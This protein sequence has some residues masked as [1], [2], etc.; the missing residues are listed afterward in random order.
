MMETVP[1]GTILHNYYRIER[2]LGSGGFGHVYQSIDLRTNQQYA[3]KEYLVTGSGGQEQLQHE[4]QMLNKLHHPNLPIFHDAFS[5]RGHYYVVLSY[6]EGNDLTDLL[7]VAR[8]RN[9]TIPLP[10][11]LNW[12][13]SICDAVTFLHSQR[14]PVIHRDIK[15]DNIRVTPEGTAILVDLGNAKAAAEGMRTLLFI[16]HQGTPGYAPPE[17]YPGG[18]GTDTRSDVY[19]LGGTLYFALTTHEPPSVSARNTSLQQGQVDLPSLQQRLASN[20]PEDAADPQRS[21]RLGVAKPQKPVPRHSRHLAQLGE[22][23]PPLLEQLNRI[24]TRALALRPEKRYQSVAE[25]SNDL[26]KVL[27]ALPVSPVQAAPSPRQVDPHSTQPDLPQLYE[28]VQSAKEQAAGNPATSSTPQAKPTVTCPRCGA[29]ITD[30]AVYCR[31][32]G[33]P[34]PPQGGNTPASNLSTSSNQAATSPSIQKPASSSPD[35]TL[36]EVD[37]IEIRPQTQVREQSRISPSTPPS[38][39]SSASQSSMQ[40]RRQDFHYSSGNGS[41]TAPT[42]SS[43][44]RLVLPPPVAPTPATGRA[45]QVQQSLPDKNVPVTQA[46]GGSAGVPTWVLLLVIFI[47]LVLIAVLLVFLLHH[48]HHGNAALSKSIGASYERSAPTAITAT[49]APAFTWLWTCC[50]G[51]AASTGFAW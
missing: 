9:E 28:A 18:T 23:P 22:L 43:A 36:A 19:A 1:S 20:P 50:A 2:V 5:E 16:R 44:A 39:P 48:G 15:P 7:R 25:M 47:L 31:V 42:S 33:T 13:I 41:T 6:I 37:T 8:M 12:M 26:R 45:I 35:R 34:L 49:A 21:F 10:R 40:Q 14:P 46:P 32:C 4:A 3:L 17:Q 29:I 30:Q 24:I 11:L 27:A 38:A 51:L